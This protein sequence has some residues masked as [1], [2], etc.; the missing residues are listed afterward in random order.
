MP[1][2]WQNKQTTNL[3]GAILKLKNVKECEIFFRDLCTLEEIAGISNRWQV[4]Q[5]LNQGLSYREIAKQ[6]E[7]STTTI[8]RVAHWIKHGRGGY[9][10]ILK[11]FN[12]DEYIK[13]KNN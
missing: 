6:T 8:T 13:E 5:L 11:R 9:K 12:K 10:L 2:H 3:F 4:A 7:L 1:K